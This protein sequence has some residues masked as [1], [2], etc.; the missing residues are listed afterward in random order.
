MEP[1]FTRA[2]YWLISCAR[3]IQSTPSYPISVRSILKWFSHLCLGFLSGLFPSGFQTKILYKFLIFPTC[4]T[5]PALHFCNDIWWSVQ[6]MKL[7]QPPPLPTSSL[8]GPHILLSTLFSNTVNV[9][10]S[11]SV[12]DQVSHPYKT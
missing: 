6:V 12:R 8:L 10:S 2:S 9:C 3:W 11:I 7:L 4:A 1:L 5:C